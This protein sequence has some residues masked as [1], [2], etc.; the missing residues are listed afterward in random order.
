[1]T[2]MS[3]EKDLVAKPSPRGT[4]QD[5]MGASR[6]KPAPM[7]EREEKQSMTRFFVSIV[8][9]ALLCGLSMAQ[10]TSSPASTE[11]PQ[12][13]Q[14]QQAQPQATQPSQPSAA[15]T[16]ATSAENPRIAP[17]SIIPVQL[18]KTLDAKKAKTGDEV[19][20]KV[21][22]DL[23]SGSGALIVPKDTKVVGHVTEAQPRNKEQKESQVSIVFDHAVMKDGAVVSLPMSIQA[24]ISPQALSGGGNNSDAGGAQPSSASDTSGS[25]P[26]AGRPSAMGG[27][28]TPPRPQS[29][30]ASGG[31]PSAGSSGSGSKPAITA[32]TQGVVGISDMK[33]STTGE[34]AQGSV[35]TSEKNNVKL[36]NGTLMLLR[37]NQ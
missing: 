18:T 4:I 2:F 17:G 22:Q 25:M 35:V 32:N 7:P 1:M 5:G 28:T 21:T 34:P 14:P 24:I 37:V 10:D 33:L 19:D 27:G 9:G 11:T 6:S 15:Q 30:S 12:Q 16:N 26:S 13:A 8:A 23:K 36:E 29:P 3:R 20:A 31:D